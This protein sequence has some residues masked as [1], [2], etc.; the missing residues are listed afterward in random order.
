MFCSVGANRGQI[1]YI[2]IHICIFCFKGGGE[3]RQHK[4]GRAYVSSLL[5]DVGGAPFWFL[6]TRTILSKNRWNDFQ[7]EHDEL[8]EQLE[9][10]RS[11]FK[12]AN[13]SP[14]SPL[15]GNT[16]VV[17]ANLGGAK[18]EP[19]CGK[20]DGSESGPSRSGADGGSGGDFRPISGRDDDARPTSGRGGNAPP[21]SGRNGDARPMSGQDG[22][23]RPASGRRLVPSRGSSRG[24]RAGSRRSRRGSN[25]TPREEIL[26]KL[27][28]N[29]DVSPSTGSPRRSS[30]RRPSSSSRSSPRYP[31]TPRSSGSAGT[32]ATNRGE[33]RVSHKNRVENGLI[34]HRNNLSH[35][36]ENRVDMPKYSGPRWSGG[37]GCG[38]GGGG[39]GAGDGRAVFNGKQQP[40]Y[41]VGGYG[42]CGENHHGTGDGRENGNV[43]HGGDLHKINNDDGTTPADPPVLQRGESGGYYED[44]FDEFLEEESEGEE[45]GRQML[46]DSED[47]TRPNGTSSSNDKKCVVYKGGDGAELS[48]GDRAVYGDNTTNSSVAGVGGGRVDRGRGWDSGQGADIENGFGADD[49]GGTPRTGVMYRPPSGSN[50]GVAKGDRPKSAARQGRGAS[51]NAG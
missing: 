34:P 28:I 30:G 39:G 3:H 9:R 40:Q 37:G 43:G 49:D 23:P 17:A 38:G 24:S 6:A 32:A 26:P 45:R 10:S 27:S 18:P 1:L 36:S 48:V 5:I 47:A 35:G 25:E 16:T 44:D 41:V 19:H 2:Y 8:L 29:G 15:I 20:G 42:D 11:A 50:R 21:I 7:D 51:F 14:T 46:K 4:N 31:A 33:K 22:D 13:P 12:L